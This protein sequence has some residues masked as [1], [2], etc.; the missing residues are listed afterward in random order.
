[1][2]TL[3]LDEIR[4]LISNITCK[5]SN[6]SQQFELIKHEL[7]SQ[8]G[9]K[10]PTGLKE[11]AREKF[12]DISSAP[13]LYENVTNAILKKKIQ[14]GETNITITNPR[15]LYRIGVL[16]FTE[17]VNLD[18][19]V[20]GNVGN[21]FAAFCNFVGTWRIKGHAENGLADKGYCGKII[22]DGLAT[23]LVGQNNQKT[24]YS[25][26]VDILVKKGCMERAMAQARGGTLVTFGAGFNSGLYMSGGTLLNLGDAG[27]LFGSGMVGGV[28]YTRQ[29]TTIGKGA[30]I[31]K[32]ESDDYV[33]I[34][35]TLRKFENELDIENLDGFSQ[36]NPI[37]SLTNTKKEEIDFRDFEKIVAEN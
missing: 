1:M 22:V 31:K 2:Y 35:N 18:L 19:T 30:Q 17:P 23:E 6:P 9:I 32:L 36:K 10:L 5:I 4:N 3:D 21:F 16:G 11:A 28:I 24:D 25:D 20:E 27:E 13:I 33:A 15:A 8:F 37:L 12:G 29:G 14:Q 34:A 26:G 7:E